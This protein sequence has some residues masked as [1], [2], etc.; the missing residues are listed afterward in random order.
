MQKNK[1]KKKKQLNSY[2][3]YSSIATQMAIIIIAG[4]FLGNYLDAQQNSEQKTFTI[5][6]S[7]LSVVL[8]IYYAIKEVEK[9]NED[10]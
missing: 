6:S 7:L 8:S 10:K 4:T 2:I 3:K 9:H 1:T 5:I